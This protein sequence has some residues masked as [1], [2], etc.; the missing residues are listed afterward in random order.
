MFG[1]ITGR[2]LG[3]TCKTSNGGNFGGASLVS[4]LRMATNTLDLVN[5][6]EKAA[7]VGV[8]MDH[9]GI[10]NEK[11]GVHIFAQCVQMKMDQFPSSFNLHSPRP[12]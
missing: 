3:K 6:V 11:Y 5:L 9:L 1:K 10:A 12:L 8:L 2:S 7:Q 4:E